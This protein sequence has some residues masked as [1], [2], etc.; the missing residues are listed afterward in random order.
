MPPK[1]SDVFSGSMKGQKNRNT[2][3]KYTSKLSLSAVLE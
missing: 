1:C 2:Q 3:V